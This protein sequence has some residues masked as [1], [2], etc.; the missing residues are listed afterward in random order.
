MINDQIVIEV[1]GKLWE[2]NNCIEKGEMFMEEYGNEYQ[3]IVIGQSEDTKKIPCDKW[4]YHSNLEEV[5]N[6][7]EN[8]VGGKDV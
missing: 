4:F 1:K 3:Y 8:V 5:I 6:Y 7:L 2:G